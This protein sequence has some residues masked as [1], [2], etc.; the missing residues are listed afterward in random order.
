MEG[1]R[2]GAGWMLGRVCQVPFV[3]A[4]RPVEP[5]WWLLA[6]PHL[7]HRDERFWPN[8]GR[9]EPARWSADAVARRPRY[10][11]LTFGVTTRICTGRHLV[12]VLATLAVV[13]LVRRGLVLETDART[14][15]WRGVAGGGDVVPT[16]TVEARLERAPAARL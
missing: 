12:E 13:V 16:V 8:P 3:L 7:L 2:L 5:G 11:F 6:S 1:L 4:G 10:A 9:I 14:V 15:A